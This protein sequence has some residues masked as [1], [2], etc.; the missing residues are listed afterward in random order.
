M[1]PSTIILDYYEVVSGDELTS[2]LPL[3]CDTSIIVHGLKHPSIHCHA[4]WAT[5]SFSYEY[6]AVVGSALAAETGLA[7]DTALAAKTNRVGETAPVADPA[8][9][10]CV[11]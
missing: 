8:V 11:V 7:A 9:M 5:A 10:F 6:G 1:V 4:V 2:F 3:R